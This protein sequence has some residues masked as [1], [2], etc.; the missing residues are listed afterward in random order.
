MNYCTK[1]QRIKL[2]IVTLVFFPLFILT[3]LYFQIKYKTWYTWDYRER[4]KMARID[5]LYRKLIGIF[6]FSAVLQGK[7]DIGMGTKL[8]P[9]VFL[10]ANTGLMSIGR[11]CYLNRGV[12]VICNGGHIITGD[13]CSF[14][15]YC[16]I[17]GHGGLFIG[18]DVRIGTG[19]VIIPA[20]HSFK[21]GTK[22]CEQ[23]LTKKGVKIGNDCWIGAGAIILDGVKIG[24]GCVIGA[25]SVVTKS[26]PAYK[27]VVGNPARVI[28]NRNEKNEKRV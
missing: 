4:E 11:N 28:K 10:N 1:W 27:I 20:N 13:H 2:G 26:V 12:V 3:G 9:H 5:I 23:P 15:P 19:V 22:I 6:A 14:G 16:V 18:S 24:Q 17:Y 7:A 8:M 21:Q 25:G